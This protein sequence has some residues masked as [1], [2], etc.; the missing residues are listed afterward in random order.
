M[1]ISTRAAGWA[2]ALVLTFV[3]EGC[4]SSASIEP[5]ELTD[6]QA[7]ALAKETY[8]QYLEVFASLTHNPNQPSDLL[9]TVVSGEALAAEIEGYEQFQG[10]GS[11]LVGSP[12]LRSVQA[13][14]LTRVSRDLADVQLAI[15][16][17]YSRVEQV[18]ADGKRR[19]LRPD[20]PLVSKSVTV[21]VDSERGNF[22]THTKNGGTYC[23]N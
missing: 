22:L 10:R 19:A 9:A 7:Y 3:L 16:L 13:L 14:G 4:N 12:T 23:A 2:A 15:C 6:E 18:G 8:R 17:D 5:T 1:G 11:S 21:R 20:S